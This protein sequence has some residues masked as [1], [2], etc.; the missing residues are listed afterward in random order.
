MFKKYRMKKEIRELRFENIE[1]LRSKLA[2][3]NAIESMYKDDSITRQQF[4]ECYARYFDELERLQ[5]GR[6]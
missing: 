4:I 2:L 5:K 1:L 6:A 3:M